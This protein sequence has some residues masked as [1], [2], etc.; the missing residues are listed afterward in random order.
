MVD[1]VWPRGVRKQD[2][3]IDEWVK[4]IAPTTD[5]R[6]WYGHDPSKWEEFRKRYWKEL[7]EKNDIVSRLKESRD[8]K[9]TFIFASK[10]EKLNNATALKEYVEKH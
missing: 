5:L 4:D 3:R 9:I 7:D 1:R 8:K 6:K 10:E 2:A